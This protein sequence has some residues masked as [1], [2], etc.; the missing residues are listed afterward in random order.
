MKLFHRVLV[1]APVPRLIG[2]VFE[3]GWKGLGL[4]LGGLGTKDL[5]PELD[6]NLNS[7]PL[8]SMQRMQWRHH[9]EP[10]GVFW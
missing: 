2:W 10:R 3:L 8:F 1:S 7:N 9:R 5:W 6:N 4:G